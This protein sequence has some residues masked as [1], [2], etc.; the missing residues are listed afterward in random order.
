M[1][2]RG[3]TALSISLALLAALLAPAQAADDPCRDTPAAEP[4]WLAPDADPE[5]LRR[6]HP[7]A[8]L[9][10]ACTRRAAAPGPA[11][12]RAER[13]ELEL[14]LA[15]I[16]HSRL[17]AAAAV[18]RTL[19][20]PAAA[21]RPI[22]AEIALARGLHALDEGRRAD[23]A[24]H[25]ERTL[26]IARALSI[27]GRIPARAL[28][29]RASVLQALRP[30][31]DALDR[32]EAALQEAAA[33]LQRAGLAEAREMGDL[34]NQRT[35]LAYARQDLPAAIAHARSEVALVRRLD[36][37]DAPDAFD[38]LASL[39][40]ML[41]QLGRH[42]EA[43]ASLR[44]GLRLM[45]L[46]PAVSPGAQLGVLN[47]LAALGLDRARWSE[48]I[49]FAEQSLQLAERAFPGRAGSKIVAMSHR[50]QALMGQARLAEA[51][52][53]YEE[54]W[55]LVRDDTSVPALRRLRLLD[56]LADLYTRLNDAESAQV[57]IDAGLAIT[58]RDAHFGYWRGRLLRHRATL[59]AA[60]GRWAEADALHAEAT[61]LI[62]A[63]IGAD[64]V[65][66]LV[67][68]VQRCLAQ[69]QGRLPGGACS[70]LRAREPRLADAAAAHRF[71]VQHALATAADAEGRAADARRHHLQ[72]LAAAQSAATPHPLWVA[73][74]ALARHLRAQRANAIAVALG[75]AAVA[76]VEAMRRDLSGAARDSERHFLADKH[77]VYRRLADWLAEDGRIDEALDVLG[78]LKAEE[79]LD[80]ER[81]AGA[82]DRVSPGP[83][84]TERER[85]WQAQAPPDGA[86]PVPA[87][88]TA[89]AA[90]AAPADPARPPAADAARPSVAALEAARVAAWQVLLDE[91]VATT[92]AAAPGSA[93]TDSGTGAGAGAGAAAPR[94]PRGELHAWYFSGPTH[95]NVVLD[96][97]LGRQLLRQPLAEPLGPRVGQLLSLIGRRADAQPQLQALHAELAAPLVHAAQ[98][99]RARRLVLHLDG[100][101]RYL[102]FAALDDGER[103]LGARFAVEQRLSSTRGI[104]PGQ[105]AGAGG[106]TS[107]STSTS[108]STGTGAATVTVAGTA[109]E[110]MRPGNGLTMA[111]PS[112]SG[113]HAAV[114]PL[115][116]R[117]FGVT[118]ALSGLPALPAVAGEVCGIVDGE[119]QGLVTGQACA[120]GVLP[121]AGWLDA[122]FT[123][124]QL[125]R[126][127]AAGDPRRRDLLHLGTH[128]VLRPGHIGRSW[129]LT[130]DAQRLSLDE[131]A[132]FELRGQALVTLSACE[133]GLGGAEG[134]DGREVDGLAAVLARRG[135]G[136]VIASLWRVD[137]RSTSA[138][139]RALYAAL[140]QGAPPATAL[141]QAQQRVRDAAGG[142]WRH[143]FHWA[144]F[145]LITPG[146]PLITSGSANGTAAAAIP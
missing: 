134:A 113:A 23:A 120:R 63:T 83:L 135:A 139:M 62:A 30:G 84:L 142:A 77:A 34:L 146:H 107:T 19:P 90:P 91:A 71:R 95:L 109:A 36:G 79:L 82:A 85:R 41:S 92:V 55:A 126:A 29:G 58:Q 17:D 93:A 39:G 131:L 132:A 138:L 33:E 43:E 122:A 53:R 106:R 1:I 14:A 32:A 97:P 11:A 100:P 60:A 111:A 47:N 8:A 101:L 115:Y 26:A 125:R 136:A 45:A 75:K 4:A 68:T 108:T 76:Q 50:A 66:T 54:A 56:N 145:T 18:L 99:A 103:P 129:L 72:A 12:E 141:Q 140:A 96:G 88:P 123:P 25:F 128:F 49:A 137:D 74:D 116:V 7:A 67:S 102:P 13:A 24:P 94:I 37:P 20:E 130:G 143:P 15:L 10:R 64:H 121:G 81:R 42:D 124:A 44:D 69:V 61:P 2:A 133:T 27:A 40:A 28:T 87:G 16:A 22:D 51:Q 98:Q 118:R 31:P 73:Y 127:A 35:M 112:G 59:A 46:H 86:P 48:A 78:L 110:A 52:S 80:F 70:E 6:N 38:A 117:A 21:A 119:V 105:Q 9:A 57:A 114:T 144:G 3:S 89:P 65:Y 5:T 104:P